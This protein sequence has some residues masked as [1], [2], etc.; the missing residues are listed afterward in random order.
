MKKLFRKLPL[1]LAGVGVAAAAVAGPAV[2]A[3]DDPQ[4]HGWDHASVTVGTVDA[5]KV[6]GGSLSLSDS[7]EVESSPMGWDHTFM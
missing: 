4:T 6:I 2:A 3:T 7:D 5:P 1:A